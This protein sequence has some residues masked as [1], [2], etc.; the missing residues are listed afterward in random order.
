[1][2]HELKKLVVWDTLGS[3]MFLIAGLP[4]AFKVH[5]YIM[6]FQKKRAVKILPQIVLFR[7]ISGWEFD[8]DNDKDS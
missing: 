2:K 6:N 5:I 4:R 7:G 1:M 3:R 8:H